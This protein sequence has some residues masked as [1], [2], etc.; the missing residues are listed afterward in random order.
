MKA[1]LE[2]LLTSVPAALEAHRSEMNQSIAEYVLAIASNL[3]IQHCAHPQFLE[4]QVNQM[5]QHL[6]PQDV[7]ELHLHPKD[8]AKLQDG[9]L[10]LNTSTLHGIAIKSDTTLAL[11]GCSIKTKQGILNGSIEQQMD[12]LKKALL[13]IKQGGLHASVV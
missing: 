11:G 12:H 5:I 13:E 4:T 2:A 8:I 3:L 10:Q 7:L 9:T 6:H 1:Q